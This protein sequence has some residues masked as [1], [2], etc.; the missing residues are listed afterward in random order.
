LLEAA[1]EGLLILGESAREAIYFHL[2]KTCSLAREDIPNQPDIFALGLEKIFGRG[3][4][5]VEESIVKSLYSKLGI[6]YK[7]MENA[8][9]TD[10]LND[11]REH[12]TKRLNEYEESVALR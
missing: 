12:K 6:R 3:A 4:K 5:V 9:F 10:Y 7:G 8:R 2:Q 11:A 1:D